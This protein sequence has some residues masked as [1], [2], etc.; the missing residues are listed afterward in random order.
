MARDVPVHA[1]EIASDLATPSEVVWQ[2]AM[3]L[4]GVNRELMPLVRM[5]VPRGLAGATL[6]DVPLGQRLGRSWLLLLGL[7]PVDYDDLTIVEREPG[8]RFFEQSTMLTQ[9]RWWHERIVEPLPGGC[10][11]VDRL[12]WQGRVRPFGALFRLAVPLLFRHR[13]RRL[14]RRFGALPRS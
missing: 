1:F 11:I 10:R 14:C 5:T 8:R 6:D 13:H 9:S 3:S 2:H 12:R 7:V 4:D